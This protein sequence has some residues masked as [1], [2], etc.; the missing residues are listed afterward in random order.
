MFSF[1]LLMFSISKV[2]K[3]SKTNLTVVLAVVVVV[4]AQ[5]AAVVA[6]QVAVVVGRGPWAETYE[7]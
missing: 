2:V 6:A 4:S 7:L 1:K 5:A 3:S